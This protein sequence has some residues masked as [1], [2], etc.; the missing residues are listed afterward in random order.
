[1]KKWYDLQ[2]YSNTVYQ[3]LKKDDAN[4]LK[5]LENILSNSISSETNM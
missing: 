2:F 3:Y 4:Y 1:M 5:M